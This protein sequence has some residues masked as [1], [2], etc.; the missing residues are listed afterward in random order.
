MIFE[1]II[2]LDISLFFFFNKTCQNIVFDIVMPFITVK[3]HLVPVLLLLLCLLFW[4]GGPTGRRVVFLLIPA[5]ALSDQLASQ[6]IKPWVSRLRPCY[7]FDSLDNIN[8]VFGSKSSPSFPSAHASNAFAAA[9][10]FIMYYPRYAFIAGCSAALIAF[11][12]VYVGVH[13]PID[14]GFGALLGIFCGVWIKYS[15]DFISSLK[16]WNRFRAGN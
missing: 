11:S 15:F 2:Q 1:S 5:I 3:E 13:Y 7:V 16:I 10:L 9:S 8:S 6:L 4:K 14:I 12:R